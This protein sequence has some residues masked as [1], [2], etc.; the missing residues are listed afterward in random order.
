MSFYE[1]NDDINDE[2]LKGFNIRKEYFNSEI[3]FYAPSIKSYETEDFKNSR[4]DSFPPFSITGGSCSLK[5][6]HCNAEILKS[7]APALTPEEL[8]GRAKAIY[9]SG[10]LGFLLSG[11]SNSKGIVDILPYIKTIKKIKSDLNLKVI[12]HCGLITEEIADGLSDAGVDSAM[13]DIIGEEDTI[14]KIYHLN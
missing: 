1:Y 11:G 12:V 6:E 8:F 2:Y 13:L 7:M 3:N 10:G 9:E 4:S 5:C 14:R